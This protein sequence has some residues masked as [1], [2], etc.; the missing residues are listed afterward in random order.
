MFSEKELNEEERAIAHYIAYEQYN[1]TE[2]EE[3]NDI[4]NAYRT[5]AQLAGCL[6]GA[7]ILGGICYV[8]IKA[9]F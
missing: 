3:Q 9:F 5:G 1:G 4:D 6:P 8:I 2:E 7:L